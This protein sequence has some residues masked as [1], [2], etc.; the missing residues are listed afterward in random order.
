MIEYPKTENLL[1]RDPDTHKLRLDEY[2]DPNFA[3]IK[4]WHVTEKIDGTNMRLVYMPRN[5][6]VGQAVEVRG[7]SDRANVHPDLRA[8]MIDMFPVDDLSR[9]FDEFI[10]E[11]RIMEGAAVT[12]F[13][14]GYGAGIQKGGG[15]L[16]PTKT[17][18]MFDVMYH[19][20]LTEYG[21]SE[22]GT[23][24]K[25]SW[26]QPSTVEFLA[27]ELGVPMVPIIIQ[28]AETQDVIDIVLGGF[29]SHVAPLAVVPEGV[30][31]RTDP[32]LYNERGSR[33]MFKLKGAD[34]E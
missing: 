22:Q 26:C 2:R 33:V 7:R 9:V 6:G 20:P 34:L 30:V 27:G 15:L 29:V 11:Q 18:R 28:Q 10:G 1:A 5:K 24:Y 16:S 12:I 4:H 14:E 17:F 3:Q 31:A 23:P 32:Y 13:G 25:H 8:A 19:W 21:T